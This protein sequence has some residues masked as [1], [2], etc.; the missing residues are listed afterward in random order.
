MEKSLR[1]QF[2]DAGMKKSQ[3][4]N[5]QSDLYVLKNEISTQLLKEYKFQNNIQTFISE[6]DGKEWYDIPFAYVE[7][8][9]AK[10]NVRKDWYNANRKH[11]NSI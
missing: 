7:H 2:L 4:G 6:I 3:L 5:W 11:G 10:I 8:F 9:K 1:E